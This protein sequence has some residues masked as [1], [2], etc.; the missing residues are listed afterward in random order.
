MAS[1]VSTA[2]AKTPLLQSN[3][4]WH[5]SSR[6]CVSHNNFNS[7]STH[8][9]HSNLRLTT[10]HHRR[11]L[12]LLR[13]PIPHSS[14]SQSHPHSHPHPHPHPQSQSQSQSNSSSSSSSSAFEQWDS[15]TAKF[16]GVSNIP[17]LLLQLPQIILNAR[18]LLAGN[19]SALFAVPWLV[20]F[21]F[22]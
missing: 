5:S 3:S 17:F 10:L 7:F 19:N 2:T 15:L 13:N 12:V 20:C 14:H 18:N 4:R 22:F 9:Y 1:N 21:F 8:S 16:A 6:L 11:P